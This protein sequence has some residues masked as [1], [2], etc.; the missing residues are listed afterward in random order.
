MI[1]VGFGLE[2]KM[3]GRVGT[4]CVFLLQT[5]PAFLPCLFYLRLRSRRHERKRNMVACTGPGEGHDFSFTHHLSV[6]LPPGSQPSHRGGTGRAAG[7]PRGETAS[8]SGP[9]GG[10]ARMRGQATA[11]SR[12]R[13]TFRSRSLV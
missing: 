2:F 3:E 6:G 9:A 8:A 5:F 12:Q 10:W 1:A 7:R 13:F 4:N 11:P